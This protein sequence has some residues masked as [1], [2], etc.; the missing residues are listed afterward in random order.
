MYG[1]IYINYFHNR[2]RDRRISAF[3]YTAL[4]PAIIESNIS[5]YTQFAGNLNSYLPGAQLVS[6]KRYC[7]IAP[8]MI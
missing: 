4:G 5:N 2:R 6:L 3:V 8:T 1:Y 7:E